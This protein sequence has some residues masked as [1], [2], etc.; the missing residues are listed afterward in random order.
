MN[1]VVQCLIQDL[2][3]MG[4]FAREVSAREW[5]DKWDALKNLEPAEYQ[6][7]LKACESDPHRRK[8][9]ALIQ[10]HDPDPAMTARRAAFD[11][12]FKG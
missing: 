4:R 6:A 11:G 7:L 10:A 5:Q 8:A 3:N 12:L 1:F 9:W 2:E